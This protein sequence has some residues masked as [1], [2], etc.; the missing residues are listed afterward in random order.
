MEVEFT[1]IEKEVSDS[2]GEDDQLGTIISGDVYLDSEQF[3]F[4]HLVWCRSTDKG[5]NVVVHAITTDSE[6]TA[7]ILEGTEDSDKLEVAS[8]PT[9]YYDSGWCDSSNVVFNSEYRD[10]SKTETAASIGNMA[11]TQLYGL[12]KRAKNA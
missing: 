9:K 4:F 10:Y 2:I 1:N 12:F 8:G 7:V 3:G 6:S 5:I 11:F